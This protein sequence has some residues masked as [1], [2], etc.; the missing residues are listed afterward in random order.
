MIQ[1]I[2]LYFLPKYNHKIN[3]VYLCYDVYSTNVFMSDYLP[4][5]NYKAFNYRGIEDFHDYN[6]IDNHGNT[7]AELPLSYWKHKMK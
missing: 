4:Q 6:I 2:L 5:T 3:S 1:L 7:S